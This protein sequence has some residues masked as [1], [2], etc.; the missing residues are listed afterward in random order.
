MGTLD[1]LTDEAPFDLGDDASTGREEE[2]AEFVGRGPGEADGGREVFGAH[3]LA[4]VEDGEALGGVAELTDVA[5][6]RVVDEAGHGL[7]GELR[8]MVA[9]LGCE[10]VE[11][12]VAQEG[13]V[14]AT[15]A[16]RGDLELHDGEAEIVAILQRRTASGSLDLAR[17]ADEDPD[18]LL[19]IARA[20]A[21]KADVKALD[22]RADLA[23][24]V[25]YM[26]PGATTY[27]LIVKE[28]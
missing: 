19:D 5:G 13:D 18:L 9:V 26:A 28:S 24:A 8:G 17:M 10:L 4:C 16:E 22:G 21:L 27:A 1:G 14:V 3:Y 25:D 6:P 23:S 12:V 11:E 7:F 15:R 2:G 20:G